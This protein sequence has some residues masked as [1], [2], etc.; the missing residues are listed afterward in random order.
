MG[1]QIDGEHEYR[2]HSV[3]ECEHEPTTE[4]AQKYLVEMHAF[5]YCEDQDGLDADDFS[6]YGD[7]QTAINLIEVQEI[8]DNV[9]RMIEKYR[10]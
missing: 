8:P 7:G 4:Q 3:M 9:A 5:G 1:E 10:L 2:I 6:T